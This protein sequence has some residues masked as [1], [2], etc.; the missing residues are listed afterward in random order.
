[1]LLSLA[2]R[3][4]TGGSSYSL[5][6]ALVVSIVCVAGASFALKGNSRKNPFVKGIPANGINS[7]VM[8][9]IGLEILSGVRF[10]ALVNFSFLGP[11]DK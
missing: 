10:G 1:M 7:H 8:S 3:V 9:K 5:N 2:R 11:D 6:G 4:T